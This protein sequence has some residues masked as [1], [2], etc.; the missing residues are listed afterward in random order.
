MKPF[1]PRIGLQIRSPDLSGSLRRPWGGRK[2]EAT[3]RDSRYAFP[4]S[5]TLRVCVCLRS[6]AV[7]LRRLAQRTWYPS[8][9]SLTLRVSICLRS[10]A[11]ELRQL[12]RNRARA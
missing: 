4:R 12:E 8:N 5:L 9:P 6:H 7:E 3:V 11:V 2:P 1:F 10:R